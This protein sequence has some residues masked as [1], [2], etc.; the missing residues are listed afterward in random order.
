MYT[1]FSDY[2]NKNHKSIVNEFNFPFFKSKQ[3]SIEDNSVNDQSAQEPEQK[4]A[5]P[6]LNINNLAA[7]QS[8]D[9]A[10]DQI[11]YQ[12]KNDRQSLYQRLGVKTSIFHKILRSYLSS[13]NGT[14]GHRDQPQNLDANVAKIIEYVLKGNHEIPSL[15]SNILD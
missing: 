13:A 9:V 12:L 4:K 3:P 2:L 7:Q 6:K 14:N 11:V 8:S 10:A 1:K 15:W 5:L